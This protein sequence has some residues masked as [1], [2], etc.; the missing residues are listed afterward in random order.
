MQHLRHTAR[1]PGGSLII[2]GEGGTSERD[3]QQCVH[4]GK[5]W[6]VELGSGRRRNFCPHHMGPLCGAESCDYC[7]RKEPG[8][9]FET[10][11]SHAKYR[12]RED[13]LTFA[14]AF[15]MHKEVGLA[16]PVDLCV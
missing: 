4:C 7:Q 9:Q 1:D 6:V 15:Q 2:V 12:R 14:S 8:M 10:A 13:K 5:S 11:T 16:L 3:T